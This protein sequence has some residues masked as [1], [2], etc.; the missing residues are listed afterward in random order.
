MNPQNSR[1][2]QKQQEEQTASLQQGAGTQAAREFASAEDAL[3]ADAG[4]VRVP[5]AVEERLSR[6]VQEEPKPGRPWWRR[7]RER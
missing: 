4:R 6:S 5:P 1:L 2:Q 7:W 3:R